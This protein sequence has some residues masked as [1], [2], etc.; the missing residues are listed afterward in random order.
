V[1]FAKTHLT[2]LLT[3]VA[4]AE[5]ACPPGSTVEELKNEDAELARFL[6]QHYKKFLDSLASGDDWLIANQ[7][8]CWLALGPRS[9]CAA[10]FLDV[11]PMLPS[12]G[13]FWLTFHMVWGFFEE[14]PNLR[15]AGVLQ[16]FRP[17]W[18]QDFLYGDQGLGLDELP[19]FITVYRSQSKN[20]RAGL[21]WT[22]DFEAARFDATG[23][24]GHEVI[25]ARV[26][27]WDI[28]GLQFNWQK[29]KYVLFGAN[30]AAHRRA[31]STE[32]QDRGSGHH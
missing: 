22:G 19:N 10:R 6:E 18:R 5:I 16:R 4:N 31:I 2:D 20:Q 8:F 28:A 32:H 7:L 14:I 11:V 24:P 9:E 21:I 12:P 30:A 1:K 17:Y 13:C 15:L 23:R 25:E 29:S 3:D 26:A 27:K